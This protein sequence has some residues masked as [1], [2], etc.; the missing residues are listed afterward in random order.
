MSSGKKQRIL[1]QVYIECLI[2]RYNTEHFKETLNYSHT[3]I[4]V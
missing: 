1:R 3:Y 4:L 2:V